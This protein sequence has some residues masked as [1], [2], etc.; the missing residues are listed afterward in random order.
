MDSYP[1]LKLADNCAVLAYHLTHRR[2][3]HANLRQ[4]DEAEER[5]QRE[6]EVPY[7]PETLALDRSSKAGDDPGRQ[8]E[9]RLGE[10]G[11]VSP[12]FSILL[13]TRVS[14]EQESRS[15]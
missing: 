2:E 6:T 8:Q 11:H 13:N 10:R 3:V 4:A 9:G 7:N 14:A 1:T 5:I 15:R 12:G